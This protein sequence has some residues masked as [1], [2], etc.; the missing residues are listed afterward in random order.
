MVATR[1][2]EGRVLP[3]AAHGGVSVGGREPE[4]LRVLTVGERLGKGA[5]RVEEGAGDIA[6]A[7]AHVAGREVARDEEE[8]AVV[9]GRV[10]EKESQGFG[11]HARQPKVPASRPARRT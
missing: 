7:E 5:V 2:V 1:G 11:R 9:L 3:G 4:K 6:H 10:L 8:A